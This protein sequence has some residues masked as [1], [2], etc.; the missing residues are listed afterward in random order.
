MPRQQKRAGD[1]LA[2]HTRT[3]RRTEWPTQTSRGSTIAG[4][5]SIAA[6]G[7]AV[8]SKSTGRHRAADSS[9]AGSSV[10]VSCRRLVQKPRSPGKKETLNSTRDAAGNTPAGGSIANVP[11]RPSQSHSNGRST[12]V[13]LRTVSD[14]TSSSRGCKSPNKTRPT[15]ASKAPSRPAANDN[16]GTSAKPDSVTRR[17]RPLSHTITSAM[18]TAPASAGA[19]RAETERRSPFCSANTHGEREK[20]PARPSH[21][22]ARA[23]T[24]SASH[25]AAGKR[26]K[27][28]LPPALT[29]SNVCVT[30]SPTRQG[31]RSNTSGRESA[32][33]KRRAASGMSKTVPS[34][35]STRRTSAASSSESGR[36]RTT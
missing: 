13:S 10:S 33:G 29:Q 31:P 24:P 5:R 35:T 18:D 27:R 14:R 19:K 30:V 12:V 6:I 8:P 16:R 23:S 11:S 28:P 34:S 15:G 25:R 20:G 32:G 36:N 21:P 2:L 1:S 26:A 4:G 9:A 22:L 3:L 7:R 17:T